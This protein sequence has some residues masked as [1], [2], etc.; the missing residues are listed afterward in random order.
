MSEHYVYRFY[1]ELSDYKPKIWRRF[2]INGE[3]TMA[4]LGYTIMLMF[5]MQA[6]HLFC[7]KENA[8]ENFLAYLRTLYTEDESNSELEDVLASPSTSDLL[9]NV[10]YELV[11]EDT[12]IMEDEHLM[13]ADKIK[14]SQVTRHSGSKLTFEYDFGDGW[15]IDLTLEE[16]E[17][18]EVSLAILP[19]VLEGK[20][21][22][23]IEDV[24]GAG[25]LENLAK[26]LKKG[27]GKEYKDFCSWLDS[28]SLDLSAF[29]IEDMN[30]RLKKLIRV[31]RESYEYHNEPTKK[32]LSLLLREYQGKG[33][34]GY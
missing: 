29:D 10:R 15:E 33:S 14:L 2:E 13:E 27:K 7:F 22:G 6:S 31:Y 32:S 5:E 30:F 1:A 20:G 18:R 12:Y 24:G 17:K 19:R 11:S 16:C 26:S 21:F 25:G 9:K 28:S 23:I 4:E 3:K 34:R 8:K